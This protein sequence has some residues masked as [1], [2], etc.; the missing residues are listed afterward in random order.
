[1][2]SLLATLDLRSVNHAQLALPILLLAVHHL[3]HAYRVLLAN[4]KEAT[5]SGHVKHV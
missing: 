5:A 2:A 4:T 3:L 1:V